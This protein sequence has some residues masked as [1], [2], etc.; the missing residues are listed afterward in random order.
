MNVD[1]MRG[2]VLSYLS[3][4]NWTVGSSRKRVLLYPWALTKKCLFS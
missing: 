4:K 2:V 3:I 1:F